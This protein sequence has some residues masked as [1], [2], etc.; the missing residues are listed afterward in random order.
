MKWNRVVLFF[1]LTLLIFLLMG[2]TFQPILNGVTLGL[3]LKGGFEILYELQPTEGT[4]VTGDLL[5]QTK[6]VLERRISVLGVAEPDISIEYPDRIRIQLAG[7]TNQEEARKILATEAH[8]TFRD[9]SGK[10]LMT[11]ADLKEGG[12]GVGFDNLGKPLVTLKLK[13]AGKFEKITK[14]YLGQQIGIYL[15]ENLLQAPWVE[16]VIPGGEATI[17]GQES[18]QAAQELAGLLNA[19][20]LPVKLKE[21]SSTS[22]SATLGQMALQQAIFA[23]LISV[24]FIFLFLIL[25][26]RIPG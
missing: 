1:L 11:G 16:S 23:G 10:V 19:G 17:T 3:D 15:D 2:F 9:M 21:I 8:L 24:I 7:V 18:V 5:S 25:F 12:A 14:D 6:D 13:D 4:K 26:Y 22:V 20:A